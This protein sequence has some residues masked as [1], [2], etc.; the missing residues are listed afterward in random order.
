[1]TQ[2]LILNAAQI[3]QRIIRIAYQIYEYNISEKEIILA[4]ITNNG[5]DFA[6]MLAKELDKICDTKIKVGKVDIDKEAHSTSEVSI[7][8]E[9]KELA[10]KCI[11]LIDDVLKSGKTAAY[12]LKSLLQ[13]NIKKIEVA[14][15]VNRSHKSFPIYPRYTGYELATTINE[16][17]EVKLQGKQKGVYLS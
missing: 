14:V 1:M 12:A 6:K 3:D 11:I 9:E 4:G 10:K 15:M 2:G 8:L 5:Y 17:V 7:D 13:V 16:H